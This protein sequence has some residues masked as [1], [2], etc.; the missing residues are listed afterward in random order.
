MK[1]LLGISGSIAAYKA[2]L[3][4]REFIKA[5]VEVRIV[6]TPSA[7][8][9]VTPLTLQNLTKHPVAI[10]MFDETTQSG[11]SWHIH[12]ARWCDMMVIA[13][14]SATTLG[15]LAHG[16]ADT[17]LA[18]VAI[19]LPPGKPLIV[20]PAM[21]SEMWRHPTTRRNLEILQ[22]DGVVVV[23]PESGEL[24]SGIIGEG[25]LP[26]IESLA[27][28]ITRIYKRVKAALADETHDEPESDD[29]R[30]RKRI[31]EALEKPDIS[32]D[33]ALEKDAFSAELELEELKSDLRG[34]GGPKTGIQG[35]TVLV[36]AGPTFEKIDDVRFVGNYSSG[37]MGFALAEAARKLGA[38]AT[39]V[40]GP[41]ALSAHPDIQR[42]DVESAEDMYRAVFEQHSA[43]DILIFAAAVAD[44]TPQ[45]QRQGKIKKQDV[46]ENF[47]LELSRTKD[48]LAEAGRRKKS[49]QC[50]IGFALEADNP[51]ENAMKK[52]R[53]K[54]CDMLVLNTLG[55]SDSGFGGDMNTITILAPDEP[56]QEFG[57]MSKADCALTILQAAARKMDATTPRSE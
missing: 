57:A 54:N 32:V 56:P 6:M 51:L 42:I 16:I 37:K 9:F 35:K 43:A 19:A 17:A 8:R 5:G 3:L 50:I 11:G 40:A 7:A 38:K 26:E 41:V 12:L 55:G 30:M 20:A 36:T 2:P 45:Q 4:A 31:R 47:S 14:C 22:R 33:E 52:M 44:F 1:L 34:A 53:D 10:D 29:E 24:A 15:R 21:D 27:A 13:P 46:G 39:L 48:I 25:R 18:A 28:G 23:P 49:E